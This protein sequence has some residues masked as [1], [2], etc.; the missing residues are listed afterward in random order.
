MLDF[1][2]APFVMHRSGIT[3]AIPIAQNSN[4]RTLWWIAAQKHF[5][6]ENIDRM[7]ALHNKSSEIKIVCG[8]NLGVS[9]VNCQIHQ[10]FVPYGIQCVPLH[11]SLYDYSPKRK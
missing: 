5:N 4:D 11:T 1:C 6:G 7:A 3:L 10:G 8:Q 9:V 2:H